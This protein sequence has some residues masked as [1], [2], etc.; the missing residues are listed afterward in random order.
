MQ[1]D[2]ERDEAFLTSGEAARLL[3]LGKKTLLRAVGRALTPAET[4]LGRALG[5][6]TVRAAEVVARGPADAGDR[7][8]RASATPRGNRWARRPSSPT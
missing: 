7:H 8:V 3:H 5:G 2:T 6:E 4:P 1:R